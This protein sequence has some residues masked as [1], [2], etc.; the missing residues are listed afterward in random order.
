MTK[1]H[2][3]KKREVGKADEQIANLK[4]THR[5]KVAEQN[6]A[7]LKQDK[8]TE[9]HLESEKQYGLRAKERA[10]ASANLDL[11]D[12]KAKAAH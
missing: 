10:A 3:D 4:D 7:S 12:K 5:A 8:A 9:A 2:E 6:T 11:H 1:A